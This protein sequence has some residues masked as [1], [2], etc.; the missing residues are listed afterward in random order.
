[1]ILS[2]I[3]SVKALQKLGR[4][5]QGE[6][7]WYVSDCP[8]VGGRFILYLFQINSVNNIIQLYSCVLSFLQFI[9]LVYDCFLLPFLSLFLTF[10]P[11]RSSFCSSLFPLPLPL[12]LFSVMRQYHNFLHSLFF[13]HFL[14]HETQHREWHMLVPC[15]GPPHFAALPGLLLKTRKESEAQSIGRMRS[16]VLGNSSPRML[17]VLDFQ[18]SDQKPRIS[19]L[20][21]LIYFI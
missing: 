13:I 11:S 14:P 21:K 5:F 7:Q 19:T 12:S 10:L 9:S 1:M 18:E 20:F 2:Q 3:L 4:L 15:L 16:P 6:S 8:E 17:Y